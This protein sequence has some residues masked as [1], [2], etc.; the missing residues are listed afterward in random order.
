VKHRRVA[1]GVGLVLALLMPVTLTMA[2]EVKLHIPPV[3]QERPSWSW[4]AVGEMV[5]KYY[6]VPAVHL[7]DYQCGIVQGGKLCTGM[8]NCVPCDLPAG[9]EATMMSL[10]GQYPVVA[11]Q[12]RTAGDI[13]LSVQ[14]KS[15]TLSDAEVR[16]ELDHGRPIVA[17]VSPSRFKVDDISQHMALI[18]GYDD[19]SGDLVLTVNDPFPYEDDRFMWIGAPYPSTKVS[20]EGNGQYEIRLE[21]FRSKLKWS[22]TIY[23]ITCAGHG[24]PSDNHQGTEGP[25]VKDDREVTQAVLAASSGDFKTLRTGHKAVDADAGTTWRSTVNFSGAKQCLVRD[26]DDHRGAGWSCLFKFEDRSEADGEVK[27]IVNRLRN[28]LP[29]GWIGTDL[30][31]DSDAELYTRTD[32]FF[33]SKPE[34]SSAISVYLIDTKKDGRVKVYLSV[35]NK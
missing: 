11:T 33:A 2:A 18:V 34:N 35:D 15:G 16:D 25:A 24:C 6:Y 22:H 28:S 29:D 19:S 17:G 23:R 26:K 14:S 21:K 5:F 12:G 7:T 10:L 27:D 3:F 13:A 4:A 8:P 31:E 32:K 9:D 30:D 1:C 20:R